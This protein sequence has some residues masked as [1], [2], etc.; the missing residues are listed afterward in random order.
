MMKQV[1]PGAAIL[2]IGPSDMSTLIAG[3]RQTYPIIPELVD[4]LR[5]VANANGAAYWDLYGVMGGYNSMIEW[6]NATP[7]L[8]RTDYIHFQQAGSARV[9]EI[10]C[11]TFFK[12][13]DNYYEFRKK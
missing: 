13:Y 6:V 9:S 4:S 12:Y 8:A 1:A 2:F 7:P 3:K 10:F 5:S 11:K